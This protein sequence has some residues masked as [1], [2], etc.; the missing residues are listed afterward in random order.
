MSSILHLGD[1]LDFI[2][3]LEDDSID[4]VFTDLPYGTTKC[5]WDKV[6]DLE[7]MWRIL[8]RI[9]KK[10][11]PILL[12]AQLPFDKTLAC[13]NLKDLRYEWIWEKTSATGHLNSK[14][15]PLKAHEQVLV[16]YKK[17]PLYNPIK[18]TGHKRK[19]SVAKRDKKQSD[20]YGEQKGVT[21]YD[22]TERHPRDVQIFKSDKQ[23]MA[24]HTTQK[25]ESLGDYF[26]KTYSKEGD[27]VLDFTMGSGTY[28]V[29]CK[30]LGRNYIGCDYDIRNVDIAKYRIDN[31][32]TVSYTHLTLPTNREV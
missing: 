5:K 28:G 18:T 16:F 31:T 1:C 10:T 29:S 19:V 25:P 9:T 23:T 11:T 7:R 15:M 3:T 14:R 6:I 24:F 20:A 22:S 4:M 26:V 21:S 17:L 8:D 30:R 27:T 13:S 12:N 2:D 32:Q